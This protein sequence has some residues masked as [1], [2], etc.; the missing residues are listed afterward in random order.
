VILVG[1]NMTFV[2]RMAG[3]APLGAAMLLGCGLSSPPARAGYTVTLEQVGS[4]VVATGSGQIDLTGLSLVGTFTVGPGVTPTVGFIGTGA[5][6]AVTTD[7]YS[8]FTGPTRFGSG[9]PTHVNSGTGALVAIEAA[10]NL[11]NVPVG[12]VSGKPLSD[13]STYD[14][15]TI[16]AIGATP[17]TYVW[18]WGSGPGDDT[19]TLQIGPAAVVPEPSSLA[20]LGAGGHLLRVRLAARECGPAWA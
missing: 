5:I 13:I 8:G 4:N 6:G 11:L 20:L 3:A 19:F 17:G 10:A 1:T 15:T 14:N 16:A 2:K 18:S 7:G 12:Y 9:G